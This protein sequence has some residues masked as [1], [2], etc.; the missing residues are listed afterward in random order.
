M[1][2]LEAKNL[3]Y[4]A[5]GAPLVAN[6]SF[7]LE[8]GTF[9][10]LI[11]PNGSGKTTLMR[12]ALGLLPPAAGAATIWG[13]PVADLSL[14]ERARKVAYLPQLRPLVWPQP[15]GDIV[16]LGRFAYGAALG[17]LSSDDQAAVARAIEACRLEGFEERAADTL[18]GGELARVH[19]ARALAAETPL[20]MA[21]EPVAA[22]DPR[23]QHET[24]QL[25]S[26]LASEGRSVLTVVHDLELAMRYADR[27][28]WMHKGK[29]VA[30]GTPLET[31]TRERLGEIFGI[32]AQVQSDGDIV[33]LDI[34][35]PK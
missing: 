10:A 22:L 25:F 7:A 21:D 31:C 17:R 8:A 28:L 9:T 26:K 27:V 20:I 16:A 5:A 12:L 32:D 23:Y 11:G 18:S 29:V 6:A 1:N 13:R 19:L 3:S 30:A 33:R 15:V 35:G 24:M 14:S 34:A 2:M 4:A